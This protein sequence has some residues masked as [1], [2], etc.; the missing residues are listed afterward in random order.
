MEPQQPQRTE[1]Q[2]PQPQKQEP[3]QGNNIVITKTAMAI[4][5][6]IDP[7]E[8]P[9]GIT[10]EEAMEPDN[11]LKNQSY[12]FLE[13]LHKQL[14]AAKGQMMGG[15][16]SVAESKYVRDKWSLAFKEFNVT[17]NRL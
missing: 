5:M 4:L 11:P 14:E 2:Q 13:E 17:Q 8:L 10:L 15:F 6:G 7:S 3:S 12:T 9:A 1:P 16:G